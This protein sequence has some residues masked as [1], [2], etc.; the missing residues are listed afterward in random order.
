MTFSYGSSEDWNKYAAIT[1]DEGWN[2]NNMRQ[3]ILKVKLETLSNRRCLILLLQNE[4]LTR[5]AD[6]HNTTGQYLPELHSTSGAVSISL[7]GF[8]TPLD[9]RV[10]STL[11]EPSFGFPYNRDT[12]GGDVLGIGK[13]LAVLYTQVLIYFRLDAFLNRQ[14]NS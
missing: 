8:L 13:V 2:W 6:N 11:Q 12:I 14:R 5:P 10:M 9:S 7:P 4:K 1:G 3:Y